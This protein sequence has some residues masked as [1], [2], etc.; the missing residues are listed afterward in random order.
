MLERRVVKKPYYILNDSMLEFWFRYVNR[1]TSLINADNGE[2][3]FH[4]AVKDHLHDF[5]GKVFEKMAKEYLL[6]HA[7]VD[8]FPILTDITDYQDIVLDV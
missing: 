8:D 7:G 1:A 4:S 6:S 5:M 2:A 3:Y